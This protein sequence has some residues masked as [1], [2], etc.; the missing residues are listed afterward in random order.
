M[1]K[2]NS[3]IRGRPQK[4]NG[5]TF[6]L[7][8]KIIPFVIILIS[9]IIA[10][11]TCAKDINYDETLIG[12][13]WFIFRG[14]PI[15]PPYAI[16]FVYIASA[17]KARFAIGELVYN[18]LKIVVVGTLVAI[19]SYFVLV[20][21][22]SVM[23]KEDEQLLASGRWG[24]KQTLKDNGLLADCG[25]VLGQLYDAKIIPSIK[26]DGGLNL[27]VKKTSQLIQFHQNVCAMLMCPSRSGK[28]ICT[29]TTTHLNYPESLI[30]VD[31]K[32]ENYENT[33]G[34]RVLFSHVYK[35]CPT[36]NETLHFNLMDEISEENPYRDANTIAS[37]L[38]SPSNPATNADPHWENT[39]RVLVTATILHC[40]CSNYEDKSLPGVYKFLSQANTDSKEDMKVVL[41][42]KMINSPHCR[43]DVHES[44]LSGAGQIL[45]AAD[46]ERGSIFSAALE[47]LEIFND[48]YIAKVTRDSDFCLDDFKYSE[49]PISLYLTVPFP[50]LKRL[51]SL[52]KLIIEFVC[53]KFSQ[54]MTS[55]GNEGLRHRILFLIDEFPTL[56]KME[57]IEEFAGILNGFG[58]SF[59]WICQSKAQID[60]LYGQNAPILD[61]CKYLVTY[62]MNE[63][64]TAEYFSKRAGTEGI[65]KQNVSNSGSRFDYGMNNMSISND[66]IERRLITANEIENLPADC[67]L[68]Y[69]QGAPVVI[70]KKVAYYSD[71]RFKYK[72]KLPKPET[73][74]EML[75]ECLTSRV[76]RPGESRWNDFELNLEYYSE[77]DVNHVLENADITQK[78]ANNNQNNSEQITNG[79]LA[80]VLI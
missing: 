31:P 2:K 64:N 25:V 55:Y 78:N 26:S 29:V 4:K 58:L 7:A 71:P 54:N 52:M 15:Y 53:R 47:A 59:L 23:N 79:E 11:Q 16:L 28:G 46:E 44:V 60:K 56:G 38:T 6:S 45:S 13:P 80:T 72:V 77:V 68:I 5:L 36:S 27:D 76:R 12:K 66:I 1:K 22:R 57:N 73:R 19:V 42:K 35:F 30:S 61:H 24:D 20:Y 43:E 40:L 3:P 67:E 48:P 75:E 39:A 21:I 69:T 37:I 62:S 10:T 34:Y 32:G 14:E 74:K 8:H 51:K 9:M 65:I 17:T 41:L 50:D 63:D 18:D 33:A 49:A 70:A